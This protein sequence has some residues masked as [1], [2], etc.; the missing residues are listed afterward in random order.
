MQDE[1]K[2]C[3]RRIDTHKDTARPFP[4]IRQVTAD[5]YRLLEDVVAVVHGVGLRVTLRK[6]YTTDGA[7]IPRV[8][9]RVAGTPFTGLY[10]VASLLHDA[11]YECELIE[12][13]TC[14]QIFREIMRHYG[15]SKWRAGIKYRA[16]RW[17]G[18]G[19]WKRH[20]QIRIEAARKF[21]QIEE[22]Q[23]G[24]VP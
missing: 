16:V 7:S 14:D 17:G 20:I 12:R 22:I 21:V 11:L 10:T 8:F 1:L 6:G 4:A 9:W 19:C 5:E 13:K 15:V 3:P 18:G 2:L 23:S 24:K